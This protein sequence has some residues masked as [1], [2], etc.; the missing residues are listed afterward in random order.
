MSTE[1]IKRV[2]DVM[3]RFDDGTF[4]WNDLALIIHRA[5][6]VRYLLYFYKNT[7]RGDKILNQKV[8]CVVVVVYLNENVK[9]QDVE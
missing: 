7:N 4:E 2:S 5:G 1:E 3:E 6:V 8:F 9:P